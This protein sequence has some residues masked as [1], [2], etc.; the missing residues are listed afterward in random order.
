M[1][2]LDKLNI[3]TG[4]G[5][6]GAL[7]RAVEGSRSAM[8]WAGAWFSDEH[9]HSIALAVSD[10]LASQ[11]VS[12]MLLRYRKPRDLPASIRDTQAA[13]AHLI[14][15]GFERIALVGHS[16]SGA[17]VISAGPKFDAIIAVAA[18]ASQTFGATTV[19]SLS[20]RPLLLIHGTED[21]RLSPYCSEQIYSWAKRPKELRFI[22]GATHGLTEH[23][24]EVFQILTT[25][26][27]KNL[28]ADS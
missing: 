13:A 20:P 23:K 25:W 1:S 3:E 27:L 18:L 2:K 21:T 28:K 12:S 5:T 22:D 26:L 6:V 16:F 17:V 24:D 15:Q 19:A 14:E 11:G 9:T 10:S 7:L 8:L 4:D